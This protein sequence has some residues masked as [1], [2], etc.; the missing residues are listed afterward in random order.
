MSQCWAYGPQ[1]KRCGQ[2]NDTHERDEVGPIHSFTV[3][4]TD[5]ECID[6]AEAI[7]MQAVPIP[8][9]TQAQHEAVMRIGTPR[10]AF[11]EPV[12]DDGEVW[13]EVP[14]DDDPPF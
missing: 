4:W 8:V 7:A 13:T 9:R 10:P 14:D 3:K 11:T 12:A 6:P 2:D 1:G 5:E